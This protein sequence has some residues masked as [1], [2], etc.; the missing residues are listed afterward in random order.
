MEV[1]A[2]IEQYIP[3]TALILYETEST[4]DK[5]YYIEKHRIEVDETGSAILCEGTPLKKE[6]FDQLVK[7]FTLT[8]FSSMSEVL[9]ENVL[10]YTQIPF[11]LTFWLKPAKRKLLFH[12]DSSFTTGEYPLPSLL[13][14]IKDKN[15]F[16]FALKENSRP[17]RD[18]RLYTL[19][20]PN[21]YRDGRVCL[22]TCKLN[23]GESVKSNIEHIEELI[24]NSEFSDHMATNDMVTFLKNLQRKRKFPVTKLQKSSVYPKLKD[25][26][27]S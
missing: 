9:P 24:F 16:L 11:R 3:K 10:F 5:K 1:K 25:L 22:G 18:S 8:H 6:T 14:D 4:S 2:L 15:L 17:D 26:L 7:S 19:P 12:K 23:I 13:I 27:E 20:L 21:I